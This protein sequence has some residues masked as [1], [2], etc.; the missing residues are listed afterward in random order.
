MEKE[1]KL[2]KAR[3]EKQHTMH[4]KEEETTSLLHS[5]VANTHICVDEMKP[6]VVFGQTIT[7]LPHTTFTLPWVDAGSEQA[8]QPEPELSNP[9]VSGLGKTERAGKGE[10]NQVFLNFL[11]IYNQN[12]QKVKYASPEGQ[13]RHNCQVCDSSYKYKKDLNRHI[14]HKEQARW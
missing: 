6:V 4:T 10:S 5:S 3:Q 11:N 12:L 7:S 14:S 8:K 1:E 13:I 2:L 9:V